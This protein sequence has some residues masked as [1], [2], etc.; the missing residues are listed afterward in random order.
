MYNER[1][2]KNKIKSY[3]GKRDVNFCDSGSHC[4]LLLVILI[5]YIF[6]VNPIMHQ[7]FWKSVNML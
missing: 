3:D 2:L 6:K 4:I 5:D 1:Y 7:Y